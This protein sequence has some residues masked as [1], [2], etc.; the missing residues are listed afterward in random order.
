MSE[1]YHNE[2]NLILVIY[3]MVD[4]SNSFDNLHCQS[5]IKN[6]LIESN[7]YIIWCI[8]FVYD[9]KWSFSFFLLRVAL[10]IKALVSG[11][12]SFSIAVVFLSQS[13]VLLPL[14]SFFLEFWLSVSYD[15]LLISPVV[16][17]ILASTLASFD[18]N[19]LNHAFF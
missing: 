18:I 7:T 1:V 5:N 3:P 2:G 10:V 15:E 4:K 12:S 8:C 6:Y 17:K 9:F 11:I 14:Q 19:V 16:L 13:V